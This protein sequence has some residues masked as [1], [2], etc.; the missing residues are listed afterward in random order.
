MVSTI[1]TRCIP[2]V[3]VGIRRLLLGTC[4][5]AVDPAVPQMLPDLH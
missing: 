2:E 1:Q 3:E 4:C 5:A